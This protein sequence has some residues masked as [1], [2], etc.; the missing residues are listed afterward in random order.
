MNK[1]LYQYS[2]SESF[3]RL[4]CDEKGLTSDVAREHLQKYGYNE[5]KTKKPNPWLRFLRQFH[6][7]LIYIL[8]LAAAITSFLSFQGEDML[9]DSIV[10]ISVVLLNAILGFIQEGKAE[11]AL[12]ALQKMLL[13]ETAVLRDGKQTILPTRELVQGDIVILEGGD[14][15]PADVRWIECKDL[16]VDESALTGES[17]AVAKH[18]EALDNPNLSPGD[19][20]CMGFSGTFLVSGFAK[21]LIVKTGTQTEFGKIATMMSSTKQVQTPLQK[22]ISEF[23]HTLI[24]AILIIG[25]LNFILGIFIGYPIA[26]IFLASVSLVVAAIPEMLPMIV[27]A[28]LALSA[29]VMAKRNALIRNLPATETLGCTTVICSDKTGTLTCNEMTV[30]Q[31]YSAGQHYQL[32]GNGYEPVGEISH[33]GHT[34]KQLPNA[35]LATLKSGLYCN[36]AILEQQ[37]EQYQI[38]GDPTEGALIVSAVKNNIKYNPENKMLD[39]IPFD[40]GR[41]YMATLHNDKDEN[42]IYIKGS[43]EVILNLCNSQIGESSDEALN[44]D[45]I[46]QQVETMANNALRVLAMAY[47]K[48]PKEY[49]QLDEMT[50]NDFCFLG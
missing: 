15:V 35:V 34:L 29:S 3:E 11:N 17:L 31:L 20:T 9:A 46:S 14:K 10:I 41:M 40:S 7:P 48:V 39:E 18:T 28:I 13:S 19:Q 33:Q 21:A 49:V 2:V 4:C 47:K 25:F 23:T 42:I 37:D 16:H 45:N 50:L 36:N 8:L 27:T 32:D 44:S 38:I 5:L 22:K 12:M 1:K 30:V 26:Y 24:I 43:P 6:N